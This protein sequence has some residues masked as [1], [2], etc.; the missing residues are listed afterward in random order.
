MKKSGVLRRKALILVTVGQ[1]GKVIALAA[2]K[3]GLTKD[4]ILSFNKAEEA[5]DAVKNIIQKGDLVLIKASRGIS[6]DKIV[7]SLKI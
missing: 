3:A 5:V 6:L 4:K 7:D 1:N 2:E